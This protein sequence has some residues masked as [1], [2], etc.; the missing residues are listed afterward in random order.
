M[1]VFSY[2]AA[3]YDTTLIREEYRK[4]VADPVKI[5]FFKSAGRGFTAHVNPNRVLATGV[6]SQVAFFR[7]MQLDPERFYIGL[8]ARSSATQV[9]DALSQ[10]ETAID[11]CV[12]DLL[13]DV[14]VLTGPSSS[15]PPP[16]LKTLLVGVARL[17]QALLTI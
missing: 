7:D 5:E 4:V 3:I 6:G 12:A 13:R 2:F 10:C 16:R 9:R 15:P 8:T 17:A 11:C 1:P 14:R